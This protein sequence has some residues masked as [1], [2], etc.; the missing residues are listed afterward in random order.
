MIVHLENISKVYYRGLF[1][2]REIRAVSN[3]NL[4][5][6]KKT[7]VSIVGE[8]G[9]GKTTVGKIAVGLVL[10]TKGR[11]RWLGEDVIADGAVINKKAFKAM[12]HKFVYI[13]QDPYSALNPSK[14]VRQ[15]LESVIRRHRG[16]LSI[17]DAERLMHELLERVGL[18]PPS[19]F[20][21]KYPHHLSGGMRQRL[22][23]ARALV[24]EPHLMV[25]DEIISMVDPSIR[26]ALIDL[27]KRIVNEMETSIIFITHDLGAAIYAAQSN[28]AYVMFR[29][30]VLE[31]G[32]ADRV[33]L[34]P[35]H[36]YT[37]ALLSNAFIPI[38][39]RPRSVR[40]LEEV[41]DRRERVDSQCPFASMCPYLSR[42]CTEYTGKLIKIDSDRY[43][44]C[45]KASE[46][47]PWKP[48]WLKIVG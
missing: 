36:P 31:A 3:F 19:Y 10:P 8:S 29:G 15:I 33:A 11:V 24:V 9:S 30:H 48:S 25:A 40:P 34:D 6:P 27:L 26:I 42:E 28:P 21:N 5:V 1:K 18:I 37:R 23:I 44:L 22:M 4:E 13:H 46:L 12:R 45:V 17:A 20:L 32:P 7:I 35:K 2:R 41:V 47:P 14:N 39:G 38:V 16:E 43:S